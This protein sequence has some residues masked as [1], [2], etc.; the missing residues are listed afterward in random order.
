MIKVIGAK[1][2]IKDIYNFLE[3]IN[4]F[5]KKNNLL[6]QSFDADL[7]FGKNHIISAAEHALR[8]FER[9]TNTTNSLEKEI[10]LYA[11]GERQ[12][13]LA[14]PKIGVK[15]GNVKIVIV[16]LNNINKKISN[17]TI[18]DLL[19]LVSLNRDD[20]VLEGDENTLKRFGIKEKELKTVNKV[21]Y[22]DLIL[23]KVAM[24]DIIK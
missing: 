5:A 20:K 13:K 9:K 15:S 7:V 6:I 2:K 21:K 22:C 4:Y 19:K 11:S 16:L 14:I 17:H 24:V 3:K 18:D 12:L 10:L 23:E 8:S 1:G